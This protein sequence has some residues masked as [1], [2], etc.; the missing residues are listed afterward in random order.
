MLTSKRVF[1]AL[2]T[3]NVLVLLVTLFR[4][5]QADFVGVGDVYTRNTQGDVV[6]ITQHTSLDSLYLNQYVRF[7]DHPNLGFVCTA[8]V[9]KLPFKK[10]LLSVNDSCR[11][12]PASAAPSLEQEALLA[13]QGYIFN[14]DLFSLY[15][16]KKLPHSNQLLLF[17]SS[18]S[19][20]E[21]HYTQQAG[22]LI[23]RLPD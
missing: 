3:I 14:R 9:F 22:N 10:R 19:N 18:P 21:V 11:A 20:L 4:F 17:R 7:P 16:Y 12:T 6:Q 13:M 1:V 8:W 5:A 23:Q 15:H 2:L